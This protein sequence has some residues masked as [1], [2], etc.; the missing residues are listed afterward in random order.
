MVIQPTWQQV[1][2]DRPLAH[3]WH[4]P[5][6]ETTALQKV[7]IWDIFKFFAAKF[8]TSLKNWKVGEES[9]LARMSDMKDKRSDF[10]NVSK[11]Q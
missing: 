9:M 10:E 8:V 5:R 3:R 2:V 1:H 7:V 11:D 4:R 6:D